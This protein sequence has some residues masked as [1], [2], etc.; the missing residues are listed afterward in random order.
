MWLLAPRCRS[1]RRRAWHLLLGTVQTSGAP[2]PGLGFAVS[3]TVTGWSHRSHASCPPSRSQRASPALDA[4]GDTASGAA[5]PQDRSPGAGGAGISRCSSRGWGSCAQPGGCHLPAPRW[6]S[7]GSAPSP[8][9]PSCVCVQTPFLGGRQL[10]G[11]ATRAQ[12]DLTVTVHIG[13]DPVL[14]TVASTGA[15]AGTVCGC[16]GRILANQLRPDL[17]MPSP[18]HR[19]GLSGKLRQ[20]EDPL[21]PQFLQS[22]QKASRRASERQA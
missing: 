6:R 13:N 19:A 16:W 15:V 1:W 18:G 9:A 14:K 21:E 20:R 22:S 8:P 5:E 10:W 3:A 7:P 2:R 4:S 17:V 11:Q 12:Q